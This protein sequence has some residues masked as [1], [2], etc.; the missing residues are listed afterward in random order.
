[1]LQL[2]DRRG[3]MYEYSTIWLFAIW[4]DRVF[5]II[6]YTAG[7][8]GVGKMVSPP[9]LLLLARLGPVSRDIVVQRRQI[10]RPAWRSGPLLV[11]STVRQAAIRRRG[12]IGGHLLAGEVERAAAVHFCGPRVGRFV[13][14]PERRL[15][16]HGHGEFGASPFP[17]GISMARRG[18]SRRHGR[19]GR[20]V[21]RGETGH[22]RFDSGTFFVG[23]FRL[24]KPSEVGQLRRRC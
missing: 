17:V 10:H 23:H 9:L 5:V 13:R 2:D 7:M 4:M 19:L 24:F 8:V 1:M 18:R 22:K 16:R 3:W 14:D 6:Q 11:P 20:A 15:G 21:S 12:I